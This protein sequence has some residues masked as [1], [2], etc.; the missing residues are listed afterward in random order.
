MSI[1]GEMH[2]SHLQGING[3]PYCAAAAL[4]LSPHPAS[5]LLDILIHCGFLACFRSK[6]DCFLPAAPGKASEHYF[7]GLRNISLAFSGF[8]TVV[9]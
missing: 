6:K 4:P 1:G 2:F 8:F 3:A 5:L 9:P 7:S